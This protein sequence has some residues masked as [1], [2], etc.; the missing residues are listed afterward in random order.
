M[1]NRNEEFLSSVDS[2]TKA[3]ILNSI[4][5]HY[6]VSTDDVI[7]EVTGDD[8]ANLLDYMVEPQRSATAVLMQRHG[9]STPASNDS[10]SRK[11]A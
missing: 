4:G 9:F 1:P 3:S 10:R 5:E 2:K 8:A 11:E 7:A 6:Q